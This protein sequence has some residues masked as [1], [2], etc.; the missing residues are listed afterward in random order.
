V[1]HSLIG[2]DEALRSWVVLH[3]SG[4][5]TD[6]MLLLSRAGRGGL[7]WL[8]VG[9]L[10]AVIRKI[11][12]IDLAP[13]VFAISL[14]T[15]TTDNVI[16]DLVERDRPFARDTRV[17][18]IGNKPNDPSFPS[19][20]ATNAFAGAAV[21]AWLVPEGRIVWFALAAAIA[22]SRVYLGVH[23]PFDVMGGALVGLACAALVISACLRS[24]TRP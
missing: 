8:L 7:I 24:R 4:A 21:L 22:Y 14:G 23:Y 6:M 1:I 10:L 9:V 2:V 3:R 16:K 11:R 5:V 12:F 20:H 13:L 18:V 17:E 15:V 19:G